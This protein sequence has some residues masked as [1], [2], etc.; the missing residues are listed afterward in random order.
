MINRVWELD[1]QTVKDY[2]FK[3]CNGVNK[4][5]HRKEILSNIKFIGEYPRVETKDRRF[6]YIASELIHEGHIC[7]HNK[8][9]YWFIP[10]WT[11][12]KEEIEW[13][14]ASILERKAK[15]LAMVQGCEK[16]LKSIRERKQYQNKFW[17]N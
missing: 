8:K 5:K 6:R 15:G 16:Q 10:L 3:K 12:N 11:K 7:S 1:K 9:G 2:L 4:A 13:V 14:E 17:R